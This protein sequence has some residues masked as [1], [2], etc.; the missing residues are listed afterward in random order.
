MAR[1]VARQ[2]DCAV[3]W[4]GE[5]F[6]M[7]LHGCDLLGAHQTTQRILAAFKEQPIEGSARVAS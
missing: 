5:E 2:M 1:Q 6:L 4:G 3:R 7:L